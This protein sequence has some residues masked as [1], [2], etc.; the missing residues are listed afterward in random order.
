ME[1]D[2]LSQGIKYMLTASFFFALTGALARIL[3]DDISNVEMVL[4]RNL[5]G[6]VFIGYSLLR[7]PPVEKGGNTGLLIFRGVIGTLALYAFFYGISKIGLAVAITYQQSY[8]VFLAVIASVF[9]GEKLEMKGWVAVLIGFAGVALIFFPQIILTQFNFKYHVIGVSNALMTGLAY[10]S[11][12]GLSEWYDERKIVL[13][14]MIC[15]IVLP[16]FSLALGELVPIGQMDF[17][18]AQFQWPAPKSWVY[19]IALGIAALIGQIFLTK[20]FFIPKT[21]LIGAIGYSNIV[22][23]VFFGVMLG[24]G[25]PG[26][27]SLL[28]ITLVIIS[29]IMISWK[30]AKKIKA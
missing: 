14:F 20:A 25:I 18:I 26:P 21:G 16:L 9:L 17:L 4:F 24:D 2:N 3:R 6:V 8:P 7:R 15:G 10:L 30:K 13:S 5:T 29:G 27:E 22:F 19:I 23:S 12:R 11:I 1:K 28:G